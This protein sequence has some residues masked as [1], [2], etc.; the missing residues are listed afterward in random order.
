MPKEIQTMIRKE[1]EKQIKTE[2]SKAKSRKTVRRMLAASLAAVMLCGVTVFAGVN[3]Y[4]MQLQKTGEHGVRVE[5]EPNEKDAAHPGSE[6]SVIPDVRMEAG[7]L[8]EGMVRTEQGKYSYE[9]TLYQGG[10]TMTFYRM[11]TGDDKFKVQHGDVLSSE[12]FTAGGY[13]G[14]YL[15]YPDLYEDEIT[16]NRRIYVAYTDVH[17]VMEMYA[18]SDVTKEDALKIAEN[19]KLIPV[20]DTADEDFVVA[21]NWSQYQESADTRLEGEGCETITSVT[22]AEMNNTHKPGNSFPIGDQGLTVKVVDVK[23][24]DDLSLL[25]AAQIDME[26]KAETDENG[27]LRPAEIQYLKTGSTDALSREIASRKVPQ[28]LVYATVEYQNTSTKDMTDVL[29]LG[30]LARIREIDGQMQIIQD[31]MP[32]DNEEWDLAVNHGLSAFREMIYYDVHGG[33]RGN[34]YIEHIPSGETVTVHM[35]WVV[36]EEELSMLYLNLDPFGGSYEFSESALK[37]GYVDIR[38]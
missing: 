35:A 5:I 34:N 14:V 13:Q 17:Y 38:Q 9:D 16:F 12:E 27:L 30:D 29:F 18:A 24:S 21:Q 37:T 1:V 33:E 2:H 19:V 26:L 28:K 15:E 36:T 32:G 3:F 8:P 4:R 6:F 20:D 11:D 22:A 10:V 7:W 23:I 25:D 31:E